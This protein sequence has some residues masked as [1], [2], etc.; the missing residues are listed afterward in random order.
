MSTNSFDPD[1]D[2]QLCPRLVNYRGK[3]RAR[4][5]HWHNG[6]VS[7]FGS[8]S[9]NLLIV[10]LAPGLKEQIEQAGLSLVTWLA[11]CSTLP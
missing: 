11:T 7:S 3:N 8:F 4:Y 9:S 1:I 10:G 2:C 5:P 6:P